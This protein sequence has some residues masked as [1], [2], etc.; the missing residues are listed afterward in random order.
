MP[1]EQDESPAARAFREFIA[2][3]PL[4]NFSIYTDIQA[5]T[6]RDLGQQV[7]ELLDVSLAEP[8][9]LTG[10]LSFY[11][12]FWLWVVA[13]FEVIRTMAEAHNCFTQEVQE[14]LLAYKRHLAKLRVPFA[15]QELRGDKGYVGNEPSM[16]GFNFAARDVLFRVGADT[17]GA[18]ELIEGF[19][20]VI[21]SISPEDILAPLPR[22]GPEPVGRD[23]L[24]EA[25]ADLRS[26]FDGRAA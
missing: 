16:Y 26:N 17:F 18:R 1:V 10:D 14:R 12:Q 7:C 15:K 24:G 23:R 25:Q 2:A 22:A 6:V 20:D 9:I 13:A 19:N 11:G 8:G 3:H 21:F 5:K 4:T